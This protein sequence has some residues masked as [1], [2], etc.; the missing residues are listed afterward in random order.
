MAMHAPAVACCG[1]AETKGTLLA[2]VFRSMSKSLIVPTVTGTSG[3]TTSPMHKEMQ[4]TN[5][6]PKKDFSLAKRLFLSSPCAWG[7]L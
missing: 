4:V 5:A 6:L 1:T 2:S 3:L 7:W